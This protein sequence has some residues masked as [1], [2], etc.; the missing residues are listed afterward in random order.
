M[1]SLLSCEDL[2][3]KLEISGTATAPPESR[4]VVGSPTD[5]SIGISWQEPALTSIHK[6]A[7]GQRL[8]ASDV[9][10]TIYRVAK[11]AKSRTIAQIKEADTSPLEIAKGTTSTRI[12]NLTVSTTYEIV[13]QSVN[14]TDTTKVSTGTRIEVTTLTTNQATAPPEARSITGS[15]IATSIGISWQAPTLTITHKQANGKNLTTAEVSY[16]IYRVAKGAKSRTIAQIKEADT[17]PLEIAKGTTSTR[18]HNL[19]V[20]TT[21]EIVVQSV[22]ATDTTKVS[23][24]TRIEV[25]TLTTNQATAPA[26]ARSITG[27]PTDTS[28]G[29]SWQEP[30]LTN[31]HKQANGQ[32]L[33]SAEVSYK[34]YRVAKGDNARTVAQITTADTSPLEIAKGTTSTRIHNLTV[35]TTYEIVVQSVNATDPTKVSTGIRIEVTTLATNQATAPAE[36][37]GIT[38]SP[39][40]TSIGISWQAPTLTSEHKQANGQNL[41][42]AEVSYKI[43]RVAKGDNA[44]TIAE[45]KGADTKPIEVAKG[46]TRTTI[47]NLTGSTHYE[48]VVQSVNAT[49]TTKVS[50]GIRIEVTT[51]TTNQATAPLDA[52]NV[53]AGS[54]TATSIGISWQAPTLTASH[55]QANGQR[56]TSAEVFYIVYRVAKGSD[57]RTIAEIKGA[58]TKPIEVAKG[59]TRTTI[60]NLTVNTHYEIV[61]QSVNATDTTKVSI[62]TRIEATTDT[63]ATAPAEARSITGS[64]TAT[65]IGISWQA[66]TLTS[67]HKTAN[68]QRLTASDVSYKIYRVAKGKHARTVA[69][70]KTADTKPIEVAKGT[71]STSIR[72]LTGNTA[73]EIVVQS[74]NATD[75]TKV[76]TGIR[77]EVTTKSQATAPPDARHVIVV[78]TTGTSTR[79]SWQA[80][81]LTSTHKNADGQRLTASDVSYKVYRVAKRNSPRTV[82]QIKT[83]DTSP[84]ET[85]KGTTNTII[86]NLI[87]STTYEIVVQAVNST[88]TTKVSTGIK[89]EVTTLNPA[90]APAEVR[91]IGAVSVTT[92]STTLSWTAPMLTSSHK[93]ANGQ[94]LTAS[95]VSYT[96]YRV[97]KGDSPR[98]IAQI[99]TADTTPLEVAKGTTSTSINNLIG[100]T[101]Y[102]IVVQSVNATDTTKV[103]AGIKKEVTTT[104]PANAP[105]EVRN[106][107]AGSVTTSSTTL[108]WTAPMLTSSHKQANGQRLTASDVSYTIYRVGKG[109]NARTIAEIKTADAS[110]LAVRKGTTS[111]TIT[112]LTR[113]TTYEIVI[114]AVNS[115][116][117]TKVST[118]IR[119]EV[120]TFAT[121]LA[122][123]PPEA[124]SIR[125]SPTATSIG[126]SWQAPTLTITHK[127]ANGQR[128]T[129]AEVSYKVYRIVKGDNARTI[130][131][132]KT[133]DASPLAVRK[134]TTWINITNLTRST[135]YEIVIVAV[136]S[137]DTTKVSTGMK[138]E[139]TTTNPANAPAEVRNI[140]A[141]SVTTSSTTLSWTAPMLTSSH[142]Q[143][144]GGRLTS[145]DISYKVYRIVKGAKSRTIA[146]IK[147]ADAS[148]LAVRKGTTSKTITNLTRN[149]TYEIVIVAVNSTDTTKVSTGMKKE[150]TTLATNQA[151]APAEARSITRSPTATS[152]GISWQA[153]TLTNSHKQANGQR[154]TSAEVSYTVYRVAKGDNARTIAEIK[155][156]D[157]SP[158]EVAKGTTSTTIPNLIVSI[159]YEIV[160]QSVN[161]TDTTK[162][163]TG[164]RLEVTT[165]PYTYTPMNKTELI[166]TIKTIIDT[167][168]DGRID[169]SDDLDADLNSID[170]SNITDMSYLFGY[171]L[172]RFNGDISNWNVSKVTNMSEM[173]YQADAF[174]SDISNWNVSKVTNMSEMFYQAD[175]FN[176]DISNWN[177]S[178]VTDMS[179]M[180]RGARAFNSDLSNWNVSSVTNMEGMFHGAKAF[181]SDISKWNVS[182]VT[183]MSGMF[184][185]ATA[186]NGDISNWNVGK[187][188]DM[189]GMF[190]GATAFNGDIS[191]WNVSKVESMSG[192][193]HGATAFNG[194]ISNWNVSKVEGMRDMFYEAT[195]FNGNIS[196]WN[197]SSVTNMG[198]MFYK[199]TAF[200]GD[201]SNWDV[202]NVKDMGVMFSGATAFNGDISNW[203]VSKVESMSDMFAGAD[204]FT[205][206][207]SNWNVSNVTNMSR[208]FSNATV[209]NSDISNW[210]VSKVTD[211][212][213]MFSGATAFNGDISNWNVGK[214]TN[215]SGMFAGAT[216][217]NSDISNWNVSSVTNMGWMFYEA[218]AFNGNIS[219]WNVSNV[220]NMSHMFYGATAFNGNISNWNVSKVTDMSRMFYK[221]T[222][223]NRDLEAWRKHIKNRKVII[224]YMFYKSGV[225]TPPSWY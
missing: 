44:R 119:I 192:M 24:G 214:V 70:I 204:A 57:A 69:Q 62:G 137:T 127:Q 103:S 104:N 68:G 84:L 120:T 218:T 100:S 4:S 96:I 39:T 184:S 12:H 52:R 199:A 168:K 197:V 135:T 181:N 93:Q 109:D 80:P 190:Q 60:P 174:N 122:T 18:I 142:K 88:D 25:T 76:S 6:Q 45:I 151:T 30:A 94:R 29:I 193:F 220:T 223:F 28:I 222:T 87:G 115:T 97:E 155:T 108:S 101:T 177:V 8:T 82:A 35:S 74:V 187:V 207:L 143:A 55:K 77:I 46:T 21:Y 225:T 41:T 72:N 90:N 13:V 59:I 160:V 134:G 217:F 180:F 47:R 166:T 61:V 54:P 5:T 211:M 200:N 91:N 19:T 43:Y 139:V 67:E 79:L 128:L 34:I 73:Y 188:M 9:S 161:A 3:V 99:K 132:I 107:V 157:A 164:I 182:K 198:W 75:T 33:T 17:S 89:K 85:T 219:N 125:G 191:N 7:N 23:T 86:N 172:N 98:T 216:V 140:V 113:S 58:D 129:T 179:E 136:N 83:A 116:D 195:A 32:R 163:S 36:A 63:L 156:A 183:H 117:T 126:I 152:I 27:S 133:A 209:F 178:K 212:S 11:G 206:D 149:T 175:A 144:N 158:L 185:Y 111:K 171:P 213:Y 224:S 165:T 145:A 150:V 147:T 64:L 53:T 14:A 38:G 141:G 203:D 189:S 146:E 121:N 202:S 110:P 186:F 215:M 114:V 124:R 154:L 66:P 48:I 205:S 159:T 118:G 2:K 208:M 148:P 123:A 15:P 92:S 201:I 131:E 22:N 56:L 153:P 16:K 40:D 10:Y 31:N 37:S 50:T 106:I 162:A 138:K 130:A 1:L 26:E 196:N 176:S 42:S 170:T 51:L 169:N 167:N 112:N 173:F 78:S 95:D 102:E 20:S 81:T 71:T 105:A 194:D 49:D 221:A 210:N 65:S